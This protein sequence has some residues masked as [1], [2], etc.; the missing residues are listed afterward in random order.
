MLLFEAVDGFFGKY[1]L[2]NVCCQNKA[3]K[4]SKIVRYNVT[5]GFWVL[6]V[7]RVAVTIV[8][9]S[10][11]LY[12]FLARP[13]GGPLVHGK[14]PCEVMFNLLGINVDVHFDLNEHLTTVEETRA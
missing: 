12:M 11:Y 3:L 4:S 2:E 6:C 7:E 1:L 5:Y 10:L 8:S 13:R 9:V 14:L